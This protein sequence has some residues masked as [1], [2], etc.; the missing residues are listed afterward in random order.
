MQILDALERRGTI[1]AASELGMSYRAVWGKIKA[2]QAR[3]GKMLVT[4]TVGGAKGGGSDSLPFQK[5][6]LGKFHYL[7]K[8]VNQAT[9]HFLRDHFAQELITQSTQSSDHKPRS[10]TAL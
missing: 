4:S 7:R 3:H 9:D 6:I 8:V 2:T 1:H 5:A 10:S